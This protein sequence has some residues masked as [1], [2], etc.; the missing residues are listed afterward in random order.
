MSAFRKLA[1]TTHPDVAGVQGKARFQ[2]LNEAYEALSDPAARA[3]YDGLEFEAP[4]QP[5]RESK[6]DP[7]RCSRCNKITAQP[8]YLI[9]WQVVSILV[10][11]VRTPIQGIF[12]ASCARRTALRATTVSAFLGWWGVPWGPIYTIGSVIKNAFGGDSPPGSE[13]K[14]LWYNALAFLS[15]GNQRLALG[16]AKRVA[17]SS[18]QEIAENA[19]RLWKE[20]EQAG[21]NKGARRYFKWVN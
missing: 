2:A 20:L 10:V 7:I 9:F 13:E 21:A 3:R 8:R 15:Q 18:N 12:C 1:K 4:K 16:I 5:T 11:T 14:L 17:G 6:L 19:S